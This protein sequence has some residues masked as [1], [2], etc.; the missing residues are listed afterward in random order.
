[1]IA[2]F[3][4][5]KTKTKSPITLSSAYAFSTYNNAS[6]ALSYQTIK[7]LLTDKTASISLAYNFVLIAKLPLTVY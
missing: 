2:C 3:A 4:R 5:F 7:Q 1:M 6:F